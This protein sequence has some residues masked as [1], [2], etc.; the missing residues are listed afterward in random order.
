MLGLVWMS[1]DLFLHTYISDSVF[2]FKE[3]NKL[4]LTRTVVLELVA[5]VKFKSWLP[6]AN[7]QLLLQFLAVDA[8]SR[9]YFGGEGDISHIELPHGV[10]DYGSENIITIIIKDMLRSRISI[11]VRLSSASMQYGISS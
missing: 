7:L 10:G 8:G 11:A 5:A 6:D 1:C 4:F 9:I 2:I 3:H